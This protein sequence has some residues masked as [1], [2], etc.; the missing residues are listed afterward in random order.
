MRADF[1]ERPI[2]NPHVLVA[3]A[4]D[5]STHIIQARPSTGLVLLGPQLSRSNKISEMTKNWMK[6]TNSEC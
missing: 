3:A 1:S 2:S 6:V 4:Q 5:F